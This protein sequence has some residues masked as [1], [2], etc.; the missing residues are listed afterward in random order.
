LATTARTLQRRLAAA[1]ISYHEMVDAARKE[2]AA[3][4]LA[5]PGLVI[6]E[7]AYLLGY[8]EPAAFHHAFKRWTDE[9]PQAYREMNRRGSAV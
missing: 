2:A 5:D 7:V 9:T 1:G 8:S 4:L 3:R 6:S